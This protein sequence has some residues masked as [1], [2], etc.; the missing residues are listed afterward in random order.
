MTSI[1]GRLAT[2]SGL[3]VEWDKAINLNL[4]LQPSAYTWDTL[5]QLL[6]NADGFYPVAIPGVT[7]F[8]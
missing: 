5:P 2:Y 3:V 7:K 6:P 4:N 1:L 8:V